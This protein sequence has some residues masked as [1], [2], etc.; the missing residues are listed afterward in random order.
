[1]AAPAHLDIN[2]L[3]EMVGT[4]HKESDRGAA[5]LAGSFLEHYLGLYL[6]SL[7]VDDKIAGKLF[8]GMGPLATFSQ[9]IAIAYAFGFIDKRQHSDLE[10]IRKIRNYFAHHPIQGTFQAEE[11]ETK[12]VML[13]TYGDSPSG[14]KADH[15]RQVY[16]FA[17]GVLCGNFETAMRRYDN[18][19]QKMG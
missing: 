13:S 16:L 8:D 5:I 17:C 3:N 7:T 4:F 19:T 12:A 18:T 11:V 2:K 10:L 6:R 9:R 15:A 14:Y 1:M